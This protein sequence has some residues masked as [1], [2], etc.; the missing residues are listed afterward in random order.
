MRQPSSVPSEYF[1]PVIDDSD[2]RLS[3]DLDDIDRDAIFLSAEDYL[4]PQSVSSLQQET[5]ID[6][7]LRSDPQVSRIF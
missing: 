4:R 6:Q 3:L 1:D 7:V 5:A 2:L